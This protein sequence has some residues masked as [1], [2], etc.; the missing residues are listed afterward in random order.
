MQISTRTAVGAW[1]AFAAALL[2]AQTLAFALGGRVEA[3]GVPA[4]WI[5]AGVVALTGTLAAAVKVPSRSVRAAWLLWAAGSGAWLAGAV[6]REASS[7]GAGDAQVL[8]NVLWGLFAVFGLVGL[9][10]RA[11]ARTFSLRLFALDALPVV[12]MMIALSWM[13]F[14]GRAGERP[15]VQIASVVYLAVYILHALSSFQLMAI[16]GLRRVPTNMWIL[17]PGFSLCAVGALL[18]PPGAN[19]PTAA[20]ALSALSWTVGLLLVGASGF[21]RALAPQ[22]FTRLFRPYRESSARALPPA[23]AVLGLVAL[24]LF[25]TGRADQIL[26]VLLLAAALSVGL[27][28]YVA[29]RDLVH[30]RE[31]LSASEERYRELFEN[32]RD[33]VFI[34]DL[35]GTLTSLNSATQ[36]LSGYDAGDL[37]GRKLSD[38]VAP[39]SGHGALL[40]LDH[41]AEQPALACE[42]EVIAKDGRRVA[43]DLNARVIVQHGEPVGWQCIARDVTERKR[44][45]EELRHQAFH[46][47][48]T[49]LANRSLFADRVEHAL[50]RRCDV[51]ESAAVLFVDVDDLKTVNDS[52]GHQVGDL[53]LVALARRLS[54]SVRPADTCAR[55]GGDEF[56]V[57]LEAVSVEGA[58]AT[59]C[60]ILAAL[61][62]PLS[63][64]RHELVA[65]AS[66]GIAFAEES[67]SP[68]ALL[69]DA[70]TAMYRAKAQGGGRYVLF[71]ADMP[72][73]AGTRLE[74]TA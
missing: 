60:R 9:T 20:G 67:E 32:A 65:S 13:A 3:V 64:G 23:L 24:E 69:R 41:A 10:L 45:T 4:A 46:D 54:D 21:R 53:L 22:S 33:C 35:D 62:S 25:T 29:R 72:A 56:A 57:L 38:I 66:I 8:P 73:P 55:L 50:S 44:F 19:A 27:R 17:C 52:L 48:L 6:T 71:E 37:V 12:L 36:I 2:A 63:I 51:D 5:V 31:A 68:E 16:D 30:S 49:G 7:L 59:A 70:D 74:L 11:P 15:V 61:Q 43:L 1:L 39:G 47:A 58:C 28:F 26:E 42:L 18:S 14:D 34:L 40:A